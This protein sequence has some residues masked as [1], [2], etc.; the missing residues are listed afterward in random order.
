MFS[1]IATGADACVCSADWLN[2]SVRSLKGVLKD[3]VGWSGEEECHV[4]SSVINKQNNKHK[5]MQF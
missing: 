2:P 5:Y 1:F 4:F 3:M